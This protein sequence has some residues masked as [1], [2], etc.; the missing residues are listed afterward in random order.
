MTDW[1]NCCLPLS[2]KGEYGCSNFTLRLSGKFKLTTEDKRGLFSHIRQ[3]QFL[4]APIFFNKEDEMRI[5][6]KETFS[7]IRIIFRG[8][9]V[10]GIL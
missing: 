8:S 7:E 4:S 10:S 2:E 5:F 9:E 3:S 6:T 1:A